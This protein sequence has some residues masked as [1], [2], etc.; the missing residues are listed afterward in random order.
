MHFSFQFFLGQIVHIYTNISNKLYYFVTIGVRV[1]CHEC[2]GLIPYTIKTKENYLIKKGNKGK[3]GE[4]KLKD[5][6][7]NLYTR[8][9]S[10]L[11]KFF[12][13]IFVPNNYF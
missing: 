3:K 12:N 11:F 2:E 10:E 9:Y 13:E 8:I 7:T 1:F 4:G 6:Q 5:Q